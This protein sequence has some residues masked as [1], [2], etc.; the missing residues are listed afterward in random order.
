MSLSLPPNFLLDDESS[1][2]KRFRTAIARLKGNIPREN[3]ELHPALQYLLAGKIMTYAGI[4]SRHLAEYHLWH[5]N[6]SEKCRGPLIS[7]F[8][9]H[10]GVSETTIQSH[11]RIKGRLVSDILTT[12]HSGEKTPWAVVIVLVMLIQLAIKPKSDRR[13]ID[14]VKELLLD[15]KDQD[16]QHPSFAT[17]SVLDV[18]QTA[19]GFYLESKSRRQSRIISEVGL[20]KLNLVNSSSRSQ[21]D[22]KP[23]L[24]HE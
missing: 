8:A 2:Q 3:Q 11:L 24:E 19:S 4:I 9:Q 15:Y 14:F 5:I 17:N 20:I 7:T 12:L 16:W 1:L 22:L 10:S 23:K 6:N 21:E 18:I 13:D